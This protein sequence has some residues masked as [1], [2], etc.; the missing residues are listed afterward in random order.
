MT[1]YVK[2]KNW[3]ERTGS[4]GAAVQS[5]CDGGGGF[6]FP[7]AS[8]GRERLSVCVCVFEGMGGICQSKLQL[9]REE[10]NVDESHWGEKPRS[11]G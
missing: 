7:A 1:S 2:L 9:L 6:S 3:Q 10:N 5:E 4:A 8:G 11:S